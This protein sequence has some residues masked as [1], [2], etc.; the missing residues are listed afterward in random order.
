[1]PTDKTE[2]LSE[3]WSSRF[4]DRDDED[5]AWHVWSQRLAAREKAMAQPIR[6]FTLPEEGSRPDLRE[7]ANDSKPTAK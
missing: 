2:S 5:L 6:N 7:A 4:D 1:M 3:V